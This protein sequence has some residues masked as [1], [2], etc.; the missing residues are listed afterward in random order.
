[1]FGIQWNPF[2][3]ATSGEQHFGPYTEVAFIERLF[4]YTNCS[5]G[6]LVP[7]RYITV[8]LYSGVAFKRVPLLT[9][10]LV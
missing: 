6:T 7:G 10:V 3:A 2:I 5:F 8:G 1:M 4:L 9:V